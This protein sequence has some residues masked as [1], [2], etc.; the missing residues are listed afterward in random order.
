MQADTYIPRRL[1]DQ[2]KIGFWDADV[3]APVLFFFFVGYVAGTKVAFVICMAIGL[4]LSR[5]IGRVKADKHPAFAL[6][7]LYWN[8]PQNPVSAL[9]VTPPSAIRR[10]VG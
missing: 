10:M 9:R 7:W 1:D 2:W 5:M 6:H 4:S 8:L 3:A